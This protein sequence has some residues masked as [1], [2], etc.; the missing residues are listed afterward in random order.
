MYKHARQHDRKEFQGRIYVFLPTIASFEPSDDHASHLSAWAY[1][2]SQGGVGFVAPHEISQKAV[3]IGMK[4]PDGA[5]RWM[6][7]RVVRSRPIPG[8]EFFDY[9]VAFQRQ[10]DAANG[11]PAAGGVK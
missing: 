1:N 3:A 10:R 2:L 7:G 8:A 9:G 5:I 6:T 11:E 4:R